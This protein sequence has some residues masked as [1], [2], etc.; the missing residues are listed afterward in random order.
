MMD[1][2]MKF[3]PSVLSLAFLII[4]AVN[5]GS[6]NKLRDDKDLKDVQQWKDAQRTSVILLIVSIVM[7]VYSGY[8]LYSKKDSL[9]AKN[10][11]Y[12]F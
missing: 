10:F 12:Y 6:L 11:I 7:I 8:D 9:F 2:V 5:L 4:A 1:M 3:L